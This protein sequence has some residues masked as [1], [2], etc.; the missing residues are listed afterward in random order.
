MLKEIE[1]NET[2]EEKIKRLRVNDQLVR[3]N[4]NPNDEDKLM[5]DLIGFLKSEPFNILKAIK[6]AIERKFNL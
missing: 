3:I 6:E 1:K 4:P 5:G 2:K